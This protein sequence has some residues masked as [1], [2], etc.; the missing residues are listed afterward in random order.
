ME[1]RHQRYVT[2]K[3]NCQNSQKIDL[4]IE[5]K[6]IMTILTKPVSLIRLTLHFMIFLFSSIMMNTLALFLCKAKDMSGGIDVKLTKISTVLFHDEEFG[7]TVVNK[8]GKIGITRSL[9]Y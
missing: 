9:N 6:A 7:R 2:Q 5:K 4:I 8:P 1:S 3:R